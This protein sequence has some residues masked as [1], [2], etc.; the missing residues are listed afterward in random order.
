MLVNKE[1]KDEGCTESFESTFWSK[2]RDYKSS[3]RRIRLT[4]GI[5]RMMERPF[6]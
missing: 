2:I 3:A 6:P 5:W 4:D 1:Y